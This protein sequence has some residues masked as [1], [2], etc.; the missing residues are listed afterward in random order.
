M[1]R[2]WL[3]SYPFFLQPSTTGNRET[4]Q[5]PTT[6]GQAPFGSLYRRAR[7]G[8]ALSGKGLGDVPALHKKCYKD[9]IGRSVQ[10]T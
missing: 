10:G 2:L 4:I 9:R 1:R 5:C 6:M 8:R 3:I 7:R